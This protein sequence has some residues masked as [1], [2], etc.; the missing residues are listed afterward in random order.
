MGY[1]NMY[2]VFR[3]IKSVKYSNLKVSSCNF[4]GDDEQCNK[5]R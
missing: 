2:N 4:P 3:N 1:C 5:Y